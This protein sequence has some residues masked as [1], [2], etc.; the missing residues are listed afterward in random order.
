[1]CVPSLVEKSLSFTF[2]MKGKEV[3]G[4]FN[5]YQVSIIS[6][7]Y[8]DISVGVEAR[9]SRI[10]IFTDKLINIEVEITALDPGC[11]I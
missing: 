3:P 8:N 6:L 7:C 10:F 2:F 5:S 1:M 4:A 11:N 9:R